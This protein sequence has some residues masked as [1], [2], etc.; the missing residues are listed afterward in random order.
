MAVFR[1]VEQSTYEDLLMHQG[2]ESIRASGEGR[3]EELFG[4]GGPWS[5]CR[6]PKPIRGQ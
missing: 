3:M 6:A 2:G 5:V 1:C 4:D